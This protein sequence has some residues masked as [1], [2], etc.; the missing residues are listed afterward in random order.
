MNCRIR[1]VAL[2]LLALVLA[3]G[4][5]LAQPVGSQPPA[6]IPA[7]YSAN[8]SNPLLQ[9][10]NVREEFEGPNT[11]D[12]FNSINNPTSPNASLLA[13]PQI[14]VGPD[15]IVMVSNSQIW[16]LPNGNAPGVIPTGLY[17]G[18]VLIGGQAFG[19]QRASLD[20]WIGTAVL[21]NLCPTGNNDPSGIIDSTN[22]RSAVTCQIDN[23]TVTYD[24]LQG[25]F[26]VLFTVVD[27]GLTFN[28]ATQ[29]FALA[30]PRKASWVL[31]VSRFAVLVD[32]ACFQGTEPVAAGGC[33]TPAIP[34]SG[35]NA[36]GSFAFVT[37]TAPAGSLT[38]GINSTI[39]AIYYGNSLSGLGSDGFGSTVAAAPGAWVGTVGAGNI[40]ALP[41]IAA[42]AAAFDC[43]PGA[44]VTSGRAA[45]VGLPTTVC[46]LPTGAR[47][48]VDNDTVTIVSPVIDANINGNDSTPVAGACGA[49]AVSGC[50]NPVVGATFQIPSY[51]GNRIRV[52]KK[53]ALYTFANLAAGNQFAAATTAPTGSYYDLFTSLSTAQGTPVTNVP[54]IPYTAILN[55]TTCVTAT[56]PN[57]ANEAT[58][59]AAAAGTPIF[60]RLTPIF[61]EPAH[62]RGRAMATFSNLP[63]GANGQNSQTY[64]VAAV[65]SPVVQS[66]LWVQGIQE[67]Y[68]LGGAP[69]ANSFGPFPFWPVLMGCTTTNTAVPC[70]GVVTPVTGGTVAVGTTVPLVQQGI[71]SQL[72]INQAF[73][74]PG[75]VS[76]LNYRSSG[77]T[78]GS[79]T[80][81]PQIFVGD[82]RPHNVIFREG[83]LYD[84][85]VINSNGQGIF[86]VPPA[87]LSTTT[88]YEIVQ[89]LCSTSS[90][91]TA[92]CPTA[93]TGT[94]LT[95]TWTTTSTTITKLSGNGTATPLTVGMLVAGTG[96]QPGTTITQLSPDGTT[97]TIVISLTPTIA[98]A[99]GTLTFTL[100]TSSGL[101]NLTYQ[102]FWQNTSAYAPMFDV[103]ANVVTFGVGTPYN[104]L[105]F[106]EK[107]FIATT[108]PPLA[109]LADTG[110]NTAPAGTPAALQGDFGSGDPRTRETFGSTGLAP[111]QLPSSGN[112]FS[113]Q[114]SPGGPISGQ[115]NSP[116]A[117]A[118]LFDTRCGT[119]VTDSNPQIR[120]PFTGVT[121]SQTAYTI[122][123]GEG[124][125]PNDGSLWNFGAYAMRRDASITSLSHWGTF[126]ANYK[127]SFPT[128]DVYGN[129]TTLF[130]DIAG[131]PEQSYIQIA[132]NQGLTPALVNGSGIEVAPP[133][134]TPIP[135]PGVN[136]TLYGSG[137]GANPIPAGV[138][139]PG[140][141]PAAGN[142]GPNDQITRREMAYWIVKSQMDEAAI[143]SYLANSVSLN[144]I[145]GYN[146]TAVSFADVPFSDPGW[147]YIEVMARRGYTAGCAAGVARRYCPD[148]ISTRRDLA[149]FMI[150][151][152]MS[153]VFPTVLSGCAFGFVS[154][155]TA[156]NSTIFPPALTT[157]C[158]SGTGDNFGLFVTGLPYFTDNPA[159][160]G[161][162][163]YVFLQKMRE[164]RI[165]NGTFLG[166]N[167]DGRNGTYN[168]GQNNVP[169][170]ND[171]GNLLRKQ[172]ATFMVRGFFF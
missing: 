19:A 9:P 165:T 75:L 60:C 83:Y 3:A 7:A 154:G 86:P 43:S 163:W 148:Y 65:S 168:I 44:V 92:G 33:P 110:Y 151:A 103:P 80:A 121:T 100:P 59:A 157:N 53:T 93:L 108:F 45:G 42:A 171:P 6:R 21:A 67:V 156:P 118:S 129:S 131:I 89:K 90:S 146:A 11:A 135:F 10:W 150:R 140:V 125:D 47:I 153:N 94:T 170:V 23:A 107:T 54:P 120:D 71:P 76:Q 96:I 63:V 88:K 164:M 91:T 16:R 69:P 104:A 8:T 166:P 24:Q 56:A 34:N 123:G 20:N 117:Y 52:I 122:R 5:G 119:D 115:P 160:T 136:A 48:G 87:S 18:S 22:T 70:L 126:A 155:T 57:Q 36:A 51:A 79:G 116:L 30:R 127:L 15:E 41:G 167:N 98:G 145:A 84:A 143:T 35:P 106:L 77:D 4:L 29:S 95:G 149:A 124:I 134:S 152:K 64:L 68:G 55:D 172:V 101:P 40:N 158:G 147:R 128:T 138:T 2:L 82:D 58:T 28:Q 112:C 13:N 73:T 114:L 72:L 169:P 144:G 139:P 132:I 74:N 37:P 97:A 1:N 85:R 133:N 99:G 102:N 162:D 161:N 49:G 12:F 109:G 66:S 46:Y 105:N 14:A 39:W 142:F 78:P 31:I 38:G 32:Q 50:Y 141:A 111:I 159:V 113:N 62:L 25:R 27:T 26:L 81:A 137:A 130:N 17:P 61:Y